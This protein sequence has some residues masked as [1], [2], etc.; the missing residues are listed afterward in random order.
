MSQS[1]LKIEREFWDQNALDKEVDIKYISDVPTEDCLKDL[2]EMSGDVLEIGCGVGRL[3]Q[4]D[5]VGIDISRE[6]VKIANKRGR[7]YAIQ[8]DGRTIPFEDNSFD[9]VYS[10]L[11]FQHLKLNAINGYIDE[12]HRVLRKDGIFT[13]QWIVGDESEPFS[14]HYS[15][16]Q[17]EE[18]YSSWTGYEMRKSVAYDG[19]TI[20]EAM[21]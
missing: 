21:K 4:P 11:L 14:N 2:P 3:M 17:I 10:Y 1:R 20:V 19:W 8:H 5:W 16:K 6:M 9:F 18:L 7:K 12:A 13:A 15:E